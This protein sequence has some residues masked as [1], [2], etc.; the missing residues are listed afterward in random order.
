MTSIHQ[1]SYSLIGKWEEVDGGGVT[2][3]YSVSG[4]YT[5]EGKSINVSEYLKSFGFS[6]GEIWIKV[7]STNTPGLYQGIQKLRDN[8]GNYFW[9]PISLQFSDSNHIKKIGV[10]PLEMRRVS[11]TAPRPV[12]PSPAPLSVSTTPHQ[13][14]PVQQRPSLGTILHM[15][16]AY[17]LLGVGFALASALAL[18]LGSLLA[19]WLSYLLPMPAMWVVFPLFMV[20]LYGYYAVPWWGAIAGVPVPYWMTQTHSLIQ[21]GFAYGGAFLPAAIGIYWFSLLHLATIYGGIAFGGLGLLIGAYLLYLA[22]RIWSRIA[23]EMIPNWIY[24]VR[25]MVRRL[26]IILVIAVIA[27]FVLALFLNS[28]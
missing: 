3:L 21:S 19:P 14:L 1:R 5:F 12:Q 23:D 18:F 24:R 2:E 20:G 26:V 15:A 11:R 8:F 28:F 4:E 7:N 22:P 10:N 27:L 17:L 13:A 6:E 16:L 9:D 25:R